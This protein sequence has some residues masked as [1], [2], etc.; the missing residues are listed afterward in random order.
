MI[1]RSFRLT[2]GFTGGRLIRLKSAAPQGLVASVRRDILRSKFHSGNGVWRR[3]R[4]GYFV[5]GPPSGI[6]QVNSNRKVRGGASGSGRRAESKDEVSVIRQRCIP[7]DRCKPV[8]VDANL[9]RRG[10]KQFLPN[11][12]TSSQGDVEAQAERRKALPSEMPQG[13][14]DTGR[15]RSS[16]AIRSHAR[17]QGQ[18]RD[19]PRIRQGRKTS[20]FARHSGRPQGLASCFRSTIRIARSGRAGPRSASVR[21]SS[22]GPVRRTSIRKVRRRF[23]RASRS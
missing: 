9:F 17:P 20:G 10:V 2:C 8:V 22:C 14:S 7:R 21:K 19:W 18:V 11:L 12:A 15:P 5:A 3:S 4:L 1:A 13:A 16:G 6:G 23:R